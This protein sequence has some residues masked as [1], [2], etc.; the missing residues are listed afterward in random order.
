MRVVWTAPAARDLEA[1]GD[2]IARHN[3]VAAHRT[4]QRIRARIGALVAHPYIGR[5]GRVA[6]TREP[7][8]TSLPFIVAY[9]VVT[10]RV[11]ILAVFHGAR[12]WPGT[13]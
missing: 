7:V 2:Y 10:D 9:R 4:V 3:P 12:I 13:F 11:E 1:I 5:P 6:S 8:V